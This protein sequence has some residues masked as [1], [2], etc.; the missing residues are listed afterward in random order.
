MFHTYLWDFLGTKGSPLRA[1][2]WHFEGA[3]E[4]LFSKLAYA[5]SFSCVML[6]SFKY[7]R[8]SLNAS[9]TWEAPTIDIHRGRQVEASSTH[10]SIHTIS[11]RQ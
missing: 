6:Y 3:I 11:R 10:H 4:H 1:A 2:S 8:R 7:D 5:I 9:V